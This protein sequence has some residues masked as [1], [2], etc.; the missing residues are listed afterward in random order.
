MRHNGRK[1]KVVWKNQT[2]IGRLF[3]LNAIQLGKELIKLDLKDKA[4]NRPTDKALK[5]GYATSLPPEKGIPSSSGIKSVLNP[6]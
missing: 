2:H 6:N 5:E 3:G 1:F 4:S